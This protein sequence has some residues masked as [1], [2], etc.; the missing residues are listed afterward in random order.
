M[1]EDLNV[2][3]ISWRQNGSEGL[4]RFALAEDGLAETLGEF[5]SRA[6]VAELAYLATCNRIELV[7]ARTAATPARDLRPLVYELLTGAAPANGEAERTLRA[8]QGEGACEH[9]FLV[10][11]GLDSAAVGEVEIT[12]QVRQCHERARS[13][14]LNGPHLDLLFEEALKIAALVRGETGL[15]TGRVSLAEVAVAHIRSRIAR[16]PGRVALVGVSPMTE[17]AAQSLAKA[18]IEL[19]FVNRTAEKAAERAGE[20]GAAHAS[21]DDFVADPPA[22]EAL[23][24]ST[25]AGNPII[26]APVLERLAVR[27]PS[28]QPPLLI[29]MAIPADIDADACARLDLTRIGMDQIT[30]EA[31]RNRE[32]R[33][34][35]AAQARELVDDALLRLHDRFAERLY[36]PLFGALQQRYRSTAQEGVKRLLKKDLRGLGD[37]ERAAIEQ[38]SEV[39][40]RRFAH[41][42]CL[43]LR[44]L[45]HHG[46]E[47]SLDAF[48]DGLEPEFADELRQALN[49]ATLPKRASGS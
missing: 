19:L 38:W 30:L 46:P 33:L 12:G 35:E 13:A 40:A 49:S 8:W 15:G 42:P 5:A 11:A 22:I 14:G 7:F 41:I 18:G 43:G 25:G 4:E 44:G 20:Y 32:A 48:L 29:D 9:L 36:G 39:L 2:V 26:D 1:L 6:G 28:R 47:G 31:E 45:L 16:T 10:A 17:R 24:T 21:L 34:V 27:T 3:G 37:E 23:L